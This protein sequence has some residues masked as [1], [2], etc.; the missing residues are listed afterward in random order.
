MQSTFR[1]GKKNTI[2]GEQKISRDSESQAFQTPVENGKVVC[3]KARRKGG[4][5]A[6]MNFRQRGGRTL[7]PQTPQ[8]GILTLRG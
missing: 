5:G 7:P 3:A 2:G 8:G 1:N 4:G 6:L